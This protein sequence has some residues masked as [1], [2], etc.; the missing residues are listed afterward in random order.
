MA[1]RSGHFIIYVS[2]VGTLVVLDNCIH[3]T[4]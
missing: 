1:K 4:G 3:D 2:I